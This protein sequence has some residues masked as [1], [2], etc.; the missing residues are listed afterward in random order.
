MV[1]KNQINASVNSC[2]TCHIAP[3]ELN[4]FGSA[5]L[6]AGISWTSALA[7]MDSDGDGF[8]NGQELGD[9]KGTG[10]PIPGAQVTLP[11]DST[12][13][14][15]LVPPN[16]S[17]DSPTNGAVFP[18]PFTGAITAST[19]NQAASI[20]SI[21]FY[22]GANLLG[23]VTTPPFSLTVSNLAAGSY[24]LTAQAKDYLGATNTSPPVTI[25]VAGASITLAISTQNGTNAILTW[26]GG[27]PP[28]VVQ[29]KTSLSDT[30]WV[31]LLNPTE[32]TATIPLDGSA[33]FL[34]LKD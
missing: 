6:D 8:T 19:T 24:V 7:A 33:G 9:P 29:K 25:T 12:D 32:R 5:F 2:I 28:F 18:A 26:S 13:K 27:A 22:N 14:P 31:D 34:R 15:T 20:T 3:P 21:D 30:N 17:I 11:G 1:S 10:T 16:I 4:P 23:A